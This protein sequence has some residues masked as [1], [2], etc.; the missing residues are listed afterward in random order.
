M[1]KRRNC[2]YK[3]GKDFDILLELPLAKG[4][5]GEVNYSCFV[6]QAGNKTGQA[7]KKIKFDA[8]PKS[9]QVEINLFNNITD[10]P[11]HIRQVRLII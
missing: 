7:V 9:S 2:Y 6:D 8:S 10:F 3:Q 4:A 5:F 11:T 1:T